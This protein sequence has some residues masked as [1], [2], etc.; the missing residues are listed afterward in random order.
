MGYRS[1][2]SEN[3][4]LAWDG[5]DQAILGYF[6][7]RGEELVKQRK[8]A[9]VLCHLK[10]AAF[11]EGNRSGVII[12]TFSISPSDSFLRPLKLPRDVHSVELLVEDEKSA[13]PLK[14]FILAQDS[15]ESQPGAR[16]GNVVIALPE[17]E[18]DDTDGRFVWSDKRVHHLKNPNAP[19]GWAGYFNCWPADD[20]DPTS[21]VVMVSSFRLEVPHLEDALQIFPVG[22]DIIEAETSGEDDDTTA[23]MRACIENDRIQNAVLT[24][25]GSPPLLY[26]LYFL[27]VSAHRQRANEWSRIIDIDPGT[28]QVISDNL[29]DAYTQQLAG[30]DD[31][32][33]SDIEEAGQN[34]IEVLTQEHRWFELTSPDTFVDVVPQE[35]DEKVEL[36]VYEISA[37]DHLVFYDTMGR[38]LRVGQHVSSDSIL[39]FEANTT[40]LHLLRG[41]YTSGHK[42]IAEI[43]AHRPAKRAATSDTGKVDT[44][45]VS[46][47]M[48]HD[49]VAAP[50][51]PFDFLPLKVHAAI[52]NG[53]NSSSVEFPWATF[54]RDPAPWLLADA[55]KPNFWASMTEF[56][57][58][59]EGNLLVRALGLLG[60]E[61]AFVN[62]AQLEDQIVTSFVVT[63]LARTSVLKTC[64]FRINGINPASDDFYALAESIDRIDVR[65]SNVEFK[66]W[67]FVSRPQIYEDLLETN[68]AFRPIERSSLEQLSEDMAHAA[69]TFDAFHGELLV[70]E[71]NSNEVTTHGNRWQSLG[72]S[73]EALE[74]LIA[75]LTESNLA[76][77]QVA[78]RRYE[79]L[80]AQF[81]RNAYYRS[82]IAS[83]IYTNYPKLLPND[84][85]KLIEFL[86]ALLVDTGCRFDARNF[87]EALVEDVAENMHGVEDWLLPNAV[88]M[89]KLTQ[90]ELDNASLTTPTDDVKK[91]AIIE[92]ASAHEMQ[93]TWDDISELAARAEDVG[94]RVPTKLRRIQ[95]LWPRESS[96]TLSEY[97]AFE[98]THKHILGQSLGEKYGYDSVLRA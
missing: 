62:L 50:Y 71:D 6:S 64:V 41:I 78:G 16:F 94:V 55:I 42:K 54:I 57:H 21:T 70:T 10:P 95:L 26:G 80:L 53:L 87:D 46:L 88:N 2:G 33:E 85:K 18:G 25:E 24:I 90:I 9:A 93:K 84:S 72:T 48:K 74:S 7:S 11:H 15:D 69:E 40:G 44:L 8:C 39:A 76:R 65:L 38:K 31:W 49:Q 79:S 92:F 98:Q 83:D 28:F 27:H 5:E 34:L 63:S 66:D 75:S 17:I 60:R 47:R 97:L 67:L 1:G 89:R 52:Q 35:T 68:G 59:R 77:D 22:Y 3:V 73:E 14:T 86:R 91:A 96:T 4:W 81:G 51:T 23:I 19:I 20:S 37:G 61:E 12:D 43:D 82:R 56:R 36:S 30:S 32:T 29:V 45:P 58:S 13:W